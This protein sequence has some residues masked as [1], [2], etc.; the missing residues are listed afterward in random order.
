MEKEGIEFGSHPMKNQFI[1][2]PHA[3]RIDSDEPPGIRR[4]KKDHG[5]PA[6]A[7]ISKVPEA[8][9]HVMED[10]SLC[11][12]EHKEVS[13]NAVSSLDFLSIPQLSTSVTRLIGRASPRAIP[14]FLIPGWSGRK[15]FAA[16]E[17]FAKWRFFSV[18]K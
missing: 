6:K 12:F 14:W 7:E 16:P 13:P 18:G 5:K 3:V 8:F 10:G 1:K 11:G 2:P 17:A 9:R 15:P 4:Q